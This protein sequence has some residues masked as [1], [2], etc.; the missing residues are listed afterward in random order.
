M[1]SLRKTSR[2]TGRTSAKIVLKRDRERK[3]KKRNAVAIE[4][5]KI[6]YKKNQ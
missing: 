3:E 5:G 4:K 1:K 6:K 2:P